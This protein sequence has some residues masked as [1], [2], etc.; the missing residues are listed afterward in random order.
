MSRRR[1]NDKRVLR[2]PRDNRPPRHMQKRRS[3][4]TKKASKASKTTMAIMVIALVAFV[5]GAGIG[6]SMALDDSSDDDKVEFENVTVEM[7][8]NLNNTTVDYDDKV[9]DIDF[10]NQEDIQEFN[11][12]NVTLSY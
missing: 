8:T 1:K 10:N 12:T 9:D 2:S 7:T 4:R 6:I 11:L 3:P 5:I